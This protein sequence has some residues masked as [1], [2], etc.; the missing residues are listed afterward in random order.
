MSRPNSERLVEVT[1]VIS[2]DFFSADILERIPHNDESADRQLALELARAEVD[3]V[4]RTEI[5]DENFKV[6]QDSLDS[7]VKYHRSEQKLM[8]RMRRSRIAMFGFGVLSAMSF[9]R[10]AQHFVDSEFTM[11]EAAV[12]T[13]MT[14]RD[15][16]DCYDDPAGTQLVMNDIWRETQPGDD[17]STSNCLTSMADELASELEES[18]SLKSVKPDAENVEKLIED[19]R[20]EA[21][22]PGD[23]ASKALTN[24]QQAIQDSIE[25]RDDSH[26]NNTMAGLLYALLGIG[27]TNGTSWQ[28]D[29]Y[30]NRKRGLGIIQELHPYRYDDV[31]SAVKAELHARRGAKTTAAETPIQHTVTTIDSQDEKHIVLLPTLAGQKSKEDYQRYLTMYELSNTLEP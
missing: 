27:L 13:T 4:V 18:R 30:R 3:E 10:S 23:A 8:Q 15:V 25:S 17:A 28:R 7:N 19:I 6:F 31:R 9:V 11:F 21:A 16:Q 29:T 22:L 5:G 2:D 26:F 12:P 20:S 1:P 14:Y 24:E